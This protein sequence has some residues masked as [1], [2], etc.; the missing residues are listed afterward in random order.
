MSDI[1]GNE[2]V[3]SSVDHKPTGGEGPT[4]DPH[5]LSPWIAAKDGKTI[6]V[7]CCL[8]GREVPITAAY[9]YHLNDA[10]HAICKQC[11]E[12]P[13]TWMDFDEE[14]DHCG[15]EGCDWCEDK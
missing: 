10:E 12:R 11:D 2:P 15:G 8:C 14:C 6:T 1:T 7:T 13:S 4:V 9:P 5:R 3:I